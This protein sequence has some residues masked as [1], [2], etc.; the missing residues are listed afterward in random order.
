MTHSTSNSQNTAL[1]QVDHFI[2]GKTVQSTGGTYIDIVSP[3]TGQ[4]AVRVA[5]GTAPMLNVAAL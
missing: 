4:V 5:S 2:D 1:Q 3:M